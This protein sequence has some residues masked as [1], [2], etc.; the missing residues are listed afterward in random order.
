MS[1]LPVFFDPFSLSKIDAKLTGIIDLDRMTRL[2]D[3]LT[4]PQVGTVDVELQFALISERVPTISGRVVGKVV[5]VCQVCLGRV[6]MPFDHRLSIGVVLTDE[7]ASKLPEDLEVL[8]VDNDER[9]VDSLEMVE[10]E[11]LLGLP[12]I[13]QHEAG[14]CP[15]ELLQS[16]YFAKKR[17]P[18]AGLSDL[19][20]SKK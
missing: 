12:M 17:N 11:I 5:G 1:A 7:Q 3:A 10:E 13:V 4:M 14:Q 18:F 20:N 9:K 19:K 16:Q 2:S 15:E 6:D 8:L